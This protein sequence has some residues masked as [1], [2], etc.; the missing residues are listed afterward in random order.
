MEARNAIAYSGLLRPF[1][2]EENE[3]DRYSIARIS[4]F[5]RSNVW[6]ASKRAGLILKRASFHSRSISSLKIA[7][8]GIPDVTSPVQSRRR[9]IEGAGREEAVHCLR[10]MPFNYARGRSVRVHAHAYYAEIAGV[11]TLISD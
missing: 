1:L 4:S 8:S 3:S 6:T 5:A 9:D 7:A 11:I 10:C 2:R